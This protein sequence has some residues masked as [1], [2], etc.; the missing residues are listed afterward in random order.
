[1]A[2]AS[3]SCTDGTEWFSRPIRSH[4][5]RRTMPRQEQHRLSLLSKIRELASAVLF[6]VDPDDRSLEAIDK[7]IKDFVIADTGAELDRSVD[8]DT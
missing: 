4:R 8:S 2:D 7:K 5:R 1:V 3:L 6:I